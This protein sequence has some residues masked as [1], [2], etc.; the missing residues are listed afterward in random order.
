MNRFTMSRRRL[1]A[2]IRMAKYGV[3]VFMLLA[4]SCASPAFFPADLGVGTGGQQDIASARTT[5]ERGEFPDPESITVSGFLSEHG[6]PTGAVDTEELLFVTA[7][8][9]YL[10]DFDSFT[11]QV[12][13]QVG[14]GTT[15]D[16]ETFRRDPLNL[17]LVIDRSGSMGNPIDVR[18]GTSK[19]DAVRV[20]IDR[21]LARLDGE[22]IVSVVTFN[23]DAGRRVDGAAG[24]DIATIKSAL[25]EFDAEGGTDLVDGLIEGYRTV[26][27][28]R[29]GGRSDRLMVFTDALL[30]RFEEF[31]TR[32]F[33]NV[34][35]QNAENGIG[36]TLFGVGTDFGHDIAYDISQVRGANYFFLGDYDRIV[37]VFDEEFDF[38]VTPVAYDVSLRVSVPFEFDVVDVYGIPFSRNPPPNVLELRIPS[39]F[40]SSRQGGGE[41]LIRTRPGA[42]VDFGREIN[43]GDVQL[44]Y[45]TPEGEMRT[46]PTISAALPANVDPAASTPYFESES[47]RRA[48]LL[49]NTALVLR[50]AVEDVWECSYCFC[51]RFGM[52]RA[53]QRLE[54]FLPYFDSLAEGL[55]DRVSDTSRSI[56]QE[57]DLLEK[58]LQNING[59]LARCNE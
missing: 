57:R 18:S 11:P 3:S 43:V 54:E 17:C 12:T 42:L 30:V 23:A 28:H 58:L 31:V 6:I 21:L 38:L 9:A 45:A 2:P 59:R 33:L 8:T 4:Y 1:L 35:E 49:L 19:L 25:T 15:I 26:N 34:L 37:S 44:S 53:A 56:S 29:G 36:V 20:A 51:G 27:R 52:S 24:N 32:R 16:R 13:L 40:L 55:E 14:F 41:I 48:V 50:R 39:L 5:I 46:Y 22:D 7:A 47:A 10:E